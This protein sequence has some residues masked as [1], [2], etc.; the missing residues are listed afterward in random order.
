MRRILREGFV[1]GIANPKTALFFA[2]VLP[3]FVDPALGR[4]PLQLAL[5]GLVFV[6]IA[7]A[8]DSISFSRRGTPSDSHSKP[9]RIWAWTQSGWHAS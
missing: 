1:V 5:L 7:L 8:S 6:A 9:C 2:A 3:Q 4:V